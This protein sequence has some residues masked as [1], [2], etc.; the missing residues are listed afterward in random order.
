MDVLELIKNNSSI[1]DVFNSTFQLITDFE[2]NIKESIETL[3]PLYINDNNIIY[4][5]P[6]TIISFLL[7]YDHTILRNRNA[8]VTIIKILNLITLNSKQWGESARLQLEISN[9][10]EHLTSTTQNL[11]VENLPILV[12]MMIY[13]RLFSQ[14]F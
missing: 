7:S 11:L 8:L 3:F 12:N 14:N 6:P 13:S 1:N 4:Q 10:D 5:L 2:D 9:N